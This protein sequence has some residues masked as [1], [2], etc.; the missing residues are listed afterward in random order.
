MRRSSLPLQENPEGISFEVPKTSDELRETKRHLRDKAVED[1]ERLFVLAALARNEWNVTRS[2]KDVGMLRPNFQA[3]MR[4]H[5]IK[6]TE[7]ED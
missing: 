6:S 1:I 3:L 7:R 2:A 4:K 5:N